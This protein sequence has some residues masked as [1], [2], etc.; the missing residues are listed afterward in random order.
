[1]LCRARR[2]QT[3]LRQRQLLPQLGGADLLAIARRTALKRPRIGELAHDH[4]VE[5]SVAH[6]TGGN[7]YC[8]WI[9]A[10]DRNSEFRIG[11][12]RLARKDHV[13][14]GIERANEP[15]SRKVF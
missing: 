12:V 10:G 2:E 11:P 5:A 3:S 9:V 8:L 15:R 4:W 13:A 6:K 14:Q 1:M 7:R